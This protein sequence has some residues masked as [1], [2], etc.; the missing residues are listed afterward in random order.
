MVTKTVAPAVP[1]GFQR[2]TIVPNLPEQRQGIVDL[3]ATIRVEPKLP[4]RPQAQV[5]TVSLKDGKGT[6]SVDLRFSPT[7]KPEYSLFTYLVL[8]DA[9][10]IKQWQ[11]ETKSHQGQVV[12]LYPDDFPVAFVPVEA[13]RALLKMAD[14]QGVLKRPDGDSEVKQSFQLTAG[15]PA[16]TLA[17]PKA[18]VGATLDFEARSRKGLGSIGLGPVPARPMQLGLPAFREYGLQHVQVRC[19]FKTAQ[20]PVVIEFLPEGRA[21]TRDDIKLLFFRPSRPE[22]TLHWHS[23]SLFQFRYRYRVRASGSDLSPQWSGYLL[24]SEPLTIHV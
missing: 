16:V 23:E 21:E 1:T 17:L 20:K 7:E 6:F 22:Q 9:A 15:Q 10:G 3:G 13:S 4:F 24:P 8:R 18:M 2:I 11:G 14:V 12:Y 19:V 5:K